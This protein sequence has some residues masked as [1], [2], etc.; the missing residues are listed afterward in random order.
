MVTLVKEDFSRYNDDYES[1]WWPRLNRFC[2]YTDNKREHKRSKF[3][4]ILASV[5]DYIVYD[6]CKDWLFN[7][8]PF[9]SWDKD[10]YPSFPKAFGAVFNN[11]LIFLTPWYRIRRKFLNGFINC[12]GSKLLDND[13]CSAYVRNRAS[14]CAYYDLEFCGFHYRLTKK[15]LRDDEGNSCN[16]F[17]VGISLAFSDKSSDEKKKEADSYVEEKSFVCSGW[18]WGWQS[19]VREL[20]K[21][22]SLTP[23]LGWYSH[24]EFD[25]GEEENVA[26][27]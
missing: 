1:I 8:K 25:K 27:G 14:E 2:I 22:V 20:N 15:I 4:R 18:V 19:A 12:N 5:K 13:Y 26:Q 9:G 6:I 3:I 17:L 23:D 11:V 7:F 10:I 16:G 21:I 24:S